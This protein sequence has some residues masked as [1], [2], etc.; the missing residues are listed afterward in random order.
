MPRNR[1]DFISVAMAVAILAAVPFFLESTAGWPLP[2]SWAGLK[3]W[4]SLGVLDFAA[5]TAWIA[6]IVCSF[7]LCR[8]VAQRVRTQNIESLNDGHAVDWLAA[9][10]AAAILS[11]VPASVA[12]AAAVGAVAPQQSSGRSLG[13]RHSAETKTTQA[14]EV[15]LGTTTAFILST[16]LCPNMGSNPDSWEASFRSTAYMPSGVN[17]DMGTTR[18]I[19]FPTSK[20]WASTGRVQIHLP[21]PKDDYKGF[22]TEAWPIISLVDLPV[23]L[24]DLATAGLSCLGAAAL[25][26]R[27]RSK[28]VA[29]RRHSKRIL[30]VHH[31]TTGPMAIPVTAETVF[32]TWGERI[33][34]LLAELA[35]ATE[36]DGCSLIRLVRSGIDGLEFFLAEPVEW[37]PEGWSI[38][39]A[40]RSWL[41]KDDLIPLGATTSLPPGCPLILP[42]GQN[43]RGAWAAVLAPRSSIA[44]LGSNTRTLVSSFDDF[45]RRPPWSK[46]VK[47]QSASDGLLFLWC[48]DSPDESPQKHAFVT[49]SHSDDADLTVIVDARALTIHPEGLSLRP[50][51]PY[52]SSDPVPSPEQRVPDSSGSD[53]RHTQARALRFPRGP[54]ESS[55]GDLEVRL[56]TVVPTI[57]GLREALPAKRARRAIEVVAYLALHH[58]DP[59]SGDRLRTRVL[60][61]PDSDAAAKT[62]FN[63]VGAARRALGSDSQGHPYLPNASRYGHYRLSEAVTLDVTRAINL[64]IAAKSANSSDESLAL[65][66]AAF[67]LVKG[68]PLAGA[69]SGYSWWRTEGHEA[70]LTATIVDA[71]C[72]AVRL[73]IDEGLLDLATWILERSRLVDP[74]SELLSR[75]AM[76]AAAASGDRT[77]LLREWDEC[78]RRANELDPGGLPSQEAEL[79]FDHLNRRRD[80]M[81]FGYHASFAAIDDAL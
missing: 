3:I 56:L 29:R 8:R 25:V 41:V 73:A 50:L 81:S 75:A 13:V 63:T 62:L 65:Y 11:V 31:E 9:R 33:Q 30:D 61:S 39:A 44:I 20:F 2:I 37:S 27:L 19:Q 18:H 21:T 4:T 58:P 10:I 17:G 7:Q 32:D 15:T 45:A 64:V 51:P 34:G 35:A 77:R 59:I 78:R 53:P 5:R 36:R 28:P 72:L 80:P 71:A 42:L 22:T 49:T 57:D 74:Y 52:D 48:I 16:A 76:A 1:V 43:S 66:R 23:L 67:D 24:S 46:S 55:P 14:R 69:L 79:L 12:S 40:G 26:R 60:G 38:G 68:E 54:V 6:W 47:V 70:R